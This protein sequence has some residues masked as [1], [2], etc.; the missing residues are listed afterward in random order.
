MEDLLGVLVVFYVTPA[1]Q[2]ERGL[3]DIAGVVAL[4]AIRI[5]IRA[6]NSMSLRG[7]AICSKLDVLT[8]PARTRRVQAQRP[9]LQGEPDGHIS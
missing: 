9:V 7:L 1:A 6:G 3:Y 4:P 2:N 8:K 5:G